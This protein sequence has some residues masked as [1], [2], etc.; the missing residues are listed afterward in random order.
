MLRLQYKQAKLRQPRQYE[1][2]M[3]N[4]KSQK[5]STKNHK[6]LPNTVLTLLKQ[7]KKSLTDTTR[8]HYAL[9]HFNQ[10]QAQAISNADRHLACANF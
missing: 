7:C 3:P 1:N 2:R 6:K 5:P 4:A 10:V 8:D 9:A